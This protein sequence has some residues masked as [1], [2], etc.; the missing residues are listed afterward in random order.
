MSE[1]WKKLDLE[2]GGLQSVNATMTRLMRHR[3]TAYLL[4][5][6]FWLGAHR[7]YL[8]SSGLGL[9]FIVATATTIALYFFAP[10]VAIGLLALTCAFA[11]YDLYWIDRR[12]ADLNKALRIQLYLRAD[13][14][15]PSNYRGR[16]T[17]EHVDI[18]ADYVEAKNQERPADRR[19]SG[20]HAGSNKKYSSFSEQEKLLR[21][22]AKSKKAAKDPS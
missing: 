17:D 13:Q 4:W 21:E 11:L 2:G 19:V 22:L 14:A 20:D 1:A 5:L 7:F 8:R 9:A 15:P 3:K 12:V 16:Y 6:L 18:L 10:K